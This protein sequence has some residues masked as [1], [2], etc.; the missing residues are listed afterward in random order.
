MRFKFVL[1][2]WLLL[3]PAMGAMGLA[4]SPTQSP[5][6]ASQGGFIDLPTGFEDLG[7]WALQSDDVRFGGLSAL[8]I[9]PESRCSCAF[10]SGSFVHPAV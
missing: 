5:L 7:G 10:R 3:W 8:L 2:G 6:K 4:Q 1:L 9:D